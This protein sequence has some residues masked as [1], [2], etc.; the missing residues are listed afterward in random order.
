MYV[1]LEHLY[2]LAAYL[3]LEHLDELAFLL[4]HQHVVLLDVL[5]GKLVQLNLLL[6]LRDAT[7]R[8][9]L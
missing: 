2:E 7:E 4:E 5:L 9:V 1:C 6:Q 3:C 8:L